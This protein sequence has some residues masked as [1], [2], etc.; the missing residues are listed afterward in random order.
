MAD[1]ADFSVTDRGL[2]QQGYVGLSA[3]ELRKLKWGLRWTP[4]LCMAGAILGL[5]TQTAWIHYALSVLGVLAVALPAH[6]PLDLLY[7]HGMRRLTGGPKLPPNPLPRATACF[8]GGLMNLGI[9]LSFQA[10]QVA[11]AYAIGGALIVLQVIVISSHFCVASWIIEGL[12]KLVGKRSERIDPRAAQQLV[13]QGALL[14]DVRSANEFA[15]GHLSAAE[16]VP[17]DELSGSVDTIRGLDRPVVVYC[18][19]G[20]RSRRAHGILRNAGIPDVYDLGPR[21][22]WLDATEAV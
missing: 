1:T 21:S 20:M 6:H 3:E 17:V 22:R 7:N 18:A 9:G 12:R 13:A 15:A 11:L 4:T 5:A 14:L 10:G 19:S 16:N 2:R 8:L